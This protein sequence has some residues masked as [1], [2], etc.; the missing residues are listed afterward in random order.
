MSSP[1]INPFIRGFSDLSVQRL[2]AIDYEADCPL[3]YR[4]LHPSQAHLKDGDIDRF[5]CTFCED[6]ALIT[7]GQTVPD[8]LDARCSGVGTVRAVVYAIMAKQMDQPRHVGDLYA[9][10]AARAV[11]ER[12]R[13][14]TGVYSRCFEIS[15][16]HLTIEA[17]E[18]LAQLADIGTPLHFLFVA[19]RIPDSWA[20]GVKLLDTPWS[21]A[22]LQS[23]VGITLADMRRL[24]QR[25]G[26]PDSLIDVIVLAATADVR[27]LV[28]DA[29]APVLDGLPIYHAD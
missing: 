14:Q 16:T 27:M 22:N 6:F 1:L 12:L 3:A 20:I 29:N 17:N 5:P 18:F 9:A 28:F 25:Q 13:F 15:S 7:E 19:F 10:D 24:M 26:M 11:V 8:E 4:P 21:D 2:V 23:L